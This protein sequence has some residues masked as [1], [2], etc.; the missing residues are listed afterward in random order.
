[1][2]DVKSNRGMAASRSF[3]SLISGWNIFGNGCC[4]SAK[5]FSAYALRKRMKPCRGTTKYLTGKSVHT[6]V[7]LHS[8]LATEAPHLYHTYNNKILWTRKNTVSCAR[9]ELKHLLSSFPRVVYNGC[10]E[11]Q[12][13][14]TAGKSATSHCLPTYWQGWLLRTVLPKVS[15]DRSRFQSVRRSIPK[16]S[17]QPNGAWV[18]SAYAACW[19]NWQGWNS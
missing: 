13:M 18:G 10:T 1:M 6:L 12:P 9:Q 15:T 4:L 16:N 14:M 2:V 8:T 7:R 5:Q 17:Y 3:S 11:Q 19:T